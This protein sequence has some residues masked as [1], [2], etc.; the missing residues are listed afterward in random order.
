[1]D[2][3]QD[4]TLGNGDVSEKLVQF[5]VI[6]DGELK[7]TWDDTGLLVITSSV[8]SQ[9]ENFSSKI[10]ENGS[11]VNW[12]TSTDTL[13]VVALSEKTMNTTDWESETGL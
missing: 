10:L 9:L 3:W 6:A 11:E 13:S 1:M 7:M 8:T 12:G 4:T 5:L 2:V